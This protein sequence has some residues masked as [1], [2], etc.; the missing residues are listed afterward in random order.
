MEGRVQAH[1]QI[2]EFSSLL[3]TTW[4]FDEVV[5]RSR[6]TLLRAVADDESSPRP[7]LYMIDFYPPHYEYEED[8]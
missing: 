5:I 3:R 4:P 7:K 6:A 8:R 2:D 1:I